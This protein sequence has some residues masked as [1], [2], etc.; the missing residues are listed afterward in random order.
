MPRSTSIDTALQELIDIAEALKRQERQATARAA[1]EAA[2]AEAE[3][4]AAEAEARAAAAEAANAIVA[5]AR[6]L[7]E[8]G[9]SAD[10][11]STLDAA[12]DHPLVAA[13]RDELRRRA[14]DEE[15]ERAQKEAEEERQRAEKERRAEALWIRAREAIEAA[16]DEAGQGNTAAAVARLRGVCPC[17][18]RRDCGARATANDG[19]HTGTRRGRS[20]RP[21]RSEARPREAHRRRSP[22]PLFLGTPKHRPFFATPEPPPGQRCFGAPAC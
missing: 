11:L 21:G 15:L 16:Q 10:A 2:A 1:A 9:R 17:A 14:A 3:A 8:E 19:A 22:R 6:A 13:A 7:F 12:E 5:T 20:N 4:R 18:S